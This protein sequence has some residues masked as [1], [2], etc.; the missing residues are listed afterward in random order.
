MDAAQPLMRPR[1]AAATGRCCCNPA[2]A[3][4]KRAQRRR[5]AG[6]CR[7]WVYRVLS[8][9]SQLWAAVATRWTV[10]T[11]IIASTLS[12]V[13][14]S[15]PAVS[16]QTQN[17]LDVFDSVIVAFFTLEFV[18]RLWSA[19]E[20]A[21]LTRYRTL[22]P[23][24]PE[25]RRAVQAAVLAG[26]ED[27][28]LRLAEKRVV[29]HRRSDCWARVMWLGRFGA[30]VDLAAVAPSYIE[31]AVAASG[32]SLQLPTLTFLRTLR[33][34]RI[35]KT[36]RYV[37]AWDAVAAA[38]CASRD[39]I[40]SG[41]IV[42]AILLLVTA[43]LLWFTVTGGGAVDV[44]PGLEALDSVP[45]AMYA[46]VLLL[47]GQGVPDGPLPASARIVVAVTA[48]LSIPV[49][50][51]PASML[52][53]SFEGIAERLR[54][55]RL[56]AR[57]RRWR[58]LLQGGIVASSSS[59][60]SGGSGGP[61]SLAGDSL[62]EVTSTDDDDVGGGGGSERRR[63]GGQG[64]LNSDD[65]DADLGGGVGG[66]GGG[67]SGHGGHGGSG[68]AASEGG[69]PVD[70]LS[71]K[72]PLRWLSATA[73]MT[74]AGAGAVPAS[75][76]QPA[77]GLSRRQSRRLRRE[78]SRRSNA[79]AAAGER[80]ADAAMW[81]R[82]PSMTHPRREWPRLWW[83]PAAEALAAHRG[84]AGAAPVAAVT[85][86]AAVASAA[87]MDF[88]VVAVVAE[89]GSC[90]EAVGRARQQALDIG[91]AVCVLEAL[92]RGAAGRVAS[93]AAAADAPGE[94]DAAAKARGRSA[95]PVCVHVCSEG[96]PAEAAAAVSVPLL[97][98]AGAGL[99]H[100]A[101][102]RLIAASARDG[103]HT[104]EGAAVWSLRDGLVALGVDASAEWA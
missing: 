80:S 97:A 18:L 64:S 22:R 65:D 102:V 42:C 39:V 31:L 70:G 62:L 28:P 30:M 61:G 51:V 76:G 50:S 11:L 13:V 96:R 67:H 103:E 53:W 99:L 85:A 57:Q 48:L 78:A 60:S 14:A 2:I 15:V 73:V 56:K 34:L 95:A 81:W 54:E 12:F 21:T 94:L 29:R 17:A 58:A 40:V 90:P 49:F 25:E 83:A 8:D 45:N 41:V 98:W 87:A 100:A 1:A 36:E 19:P 23:M 9:R 43:A 16:E 69:D 77:S 5:W 27:T 72:A 63:F 92:E 3:A 47:T 24:S 79:A 59:S 75:G 35:L 52:A 86:A 74:G 26:D 38:V 4:L 7:R 10:T 44:P 20:S 66:G 33:L 71:D 101:R 104:R 82:Q 91:S 6:S 46:T 37:F 55:K 93:R 32:T 89:H 84:T 88:E 68:A